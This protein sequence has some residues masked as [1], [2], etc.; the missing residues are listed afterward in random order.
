MSYVLINVG[1]DLPYRRNNCTMVY[2]TVPA[3]K[4][5]RTKLNKLD[6]GINQ[7]TLMTTSDYMMK[8]VPMK[9]VKNLMTGAMIQI[10]VDTP[11]GSDPSQ[12]L[13]WTM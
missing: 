11:R 12:E 4:A 13:Y 9:T 7:W 1:T 2:R 5:Q 8:P 6:G 3:A 10:P